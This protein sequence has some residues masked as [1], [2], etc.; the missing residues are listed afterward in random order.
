MATI[1]D[2]QVAAAQ[3]GWSLNQSSDSAQLGQYRVFCKGTARLTVD[4][5]PLDDHVR[6]T[7]R[8]AGCRF[9]VKRDGGE[10]VMDLIVNDR[11]LGS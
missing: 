6:G 8:V 11:W 2:L 10:G 1:T 7:L 4:V 3:H 5:C 9:D